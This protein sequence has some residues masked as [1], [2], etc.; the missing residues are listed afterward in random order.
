MARP[1]SHT[2][3]GP[4]SSRSA[5][6]PHFIAPRQKFDTPERVTNAGTTG[7]YSQAKD[8]ANSAHRPGCM[9]AFSLPSRGVGC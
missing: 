8:W 4:M 6:V 1:K 5:H 3:I 7:I 2:S 9:R